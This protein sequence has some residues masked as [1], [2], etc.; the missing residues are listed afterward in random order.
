[1]QYYVELRYEVQRKHKP[2]LVP[3]SEIACGKG[4]TFRSVYA[5]D[6]PTA[7]H[8]LEYGIT[9]GLEDVAVYSDTLFI[10]VD[11]DEEVASI[12]ED[13]I[14]QNVKF[15]QWVTGNRGCH[16][17]VS[18][19]PVYGKMV[20]QSQAQWVYLR[21][22]DS[23]DSSI[24]RPSGQIRIPGAVHSK[25]GKVK[26]LT[27]IRE[28]SQVDIPQLTALPPKPRTEIKTATRSSYVAN[29]TRYC[30]HYRHRHIMIIVKEGISLELPYEHILND[31]LR[32]NAG[33]WVTV[34]LPEAEVEQH[35]RKTYLQHRR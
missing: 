18:C 28:G 35:V 32:W 34:P 19:I 33:G 11:R 2:I 8:I 27:D 20:P 31:V 9:R 5:Y 6:E 14:S 22:G 4:M 12:K 10:D 17:H 7:N 23:V 29:L 25:T 30:E 3:I 21:Y 15:S 13:L 24:Y 16:F 1:M 26:T